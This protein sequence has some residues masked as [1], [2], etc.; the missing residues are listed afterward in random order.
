MSPLPKNTARD[1]LHRARLV[2]ADRPVFSAD[3]CHLH[4][5]DA[6]SMWKCIRYIE[7]NFEKHNLPNPHHD[8]V[9]PYDNWPFHKGSRAA[10]KP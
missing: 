9:S 5:S 8:F 7:S 6:E 1:A 3:C 2:P 4:E 10:D